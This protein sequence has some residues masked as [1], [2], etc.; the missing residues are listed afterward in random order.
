MNLHHPNF[1]LNYETDDMIPNNE[2]SSFFPRWFVFLY[3]SFCVYL[4]VPIGDVPL[5]GLSLSAPIFFILA[6]HAFI[7][8]PEAWFKK[9][10]NWLFLA[11]SIWVGTAS[12][13]FV[14]ELFG[15]NVTFNFS[16]ASILVY[17]AYWMVVFVV[18]VYI[19]SHQ[20]MLRCFRS[21]IN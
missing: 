15:S 9:F 13:F 10:E 19:C 5:L 12:S 21:G 16:G 14:N 7:K 2:K 1:H 4:T 18:T 3:A 20:K 17:F 8:P 11:A 6:I